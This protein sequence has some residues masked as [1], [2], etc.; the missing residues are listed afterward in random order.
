MDLA[1][2]LRVERARRHWAQEEL[3]RKAGVSLGAISHLERGV[4]AD[5]HLSTL[6]G[7]AGALDMS[8]AQLIGEAE[9][10]NRS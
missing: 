3:A 10:K 8:V 6:N 2:R 1:T 4:S 7:I 9:K 5:P